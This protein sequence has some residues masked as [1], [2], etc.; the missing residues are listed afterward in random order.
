MVTAE[1]AS[2][3]IV[4]GQGH[5]CVSPSTAANLYFPLLAGVTSGDHCMDGNAWGGQ[6]QFPGM[7]QYR[8]VRVAIGSPPGSV[9]EAGTSANL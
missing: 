7:V 8:L 1:D 2:K 3:E 9:A 6:Q 5:R 4:E